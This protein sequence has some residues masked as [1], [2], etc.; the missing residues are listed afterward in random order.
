MKIQAGIKAAQRTANNQPPTPPEGEPP[1]KDEKTLTDKVIIGLKAGG[2]AAGGGLAGMFLGGVG[3]KMLSNTTGMTMFKDYG[4]I[5]GGVAGAAAGLGAQTDNEVLKRSMYAQAAATA[6]MT[7]GMYGGDLAGK[8]LTEMGAGAQFATNGTLVGALALATAGASFA[9][10][11]DTEFGD[12]LKDFKGTV[13]GGSVGWGVGGAAQA[14]AS[15]F[16]PSLSPAMAFAPALYGATG[17][18]LGASGSMNDNYYD[19]YGNQDGDDEKT[20]YEKFGEGVKVAS[21]FGVG[22]SIGFTAGAGAGAAIEALSSSLPGLASHYGVTA[23]ALGAATGG[24]VAAAVET[25][26]EGWARAARVTGLGGVGAVLGDVA[27]F[28]LSKLT[29]MPIYSQLGQAAGAIT[30]ASG[31]AMIDGTDTKMGKFG[32]Y[33]FP[34]TFGTVGG[35]AAGAAVGA[36]LSWALDSA[37][38]QTVGSGLG[39]LAGG[40]TG[41]AYSLKRA[42]DR[43]NGG[44]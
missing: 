25:Q 23:P 36:L 39:T 8:F 17:A 22:A 41:L 43:N 15:N 28:G 26:N 42:Q 7:A 3:G 20:R 33:A 30:G 4:G 12:K 13:L 32:S 9:F 44:E 1:K 16:A 18:M 6:G 24:M 31:A 19:S 34:V 5:I 14:L 21:R 10:G 27:G 37:A 29:G 35:S 11:S 40:L 38:Y 2:A